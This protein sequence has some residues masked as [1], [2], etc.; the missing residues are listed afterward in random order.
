MTER[1]CAQGNH[2]VR[3]EQFRVSG[4]GRPVRD[5]RMCEAARAKALSG[6]EILNHLRTDGVDI[7]AIH[8]NPRF[9][10]KAA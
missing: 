10:R 8:R 1:W 9:A 2:F 4:T 5:C 6:R 3:L 7:D